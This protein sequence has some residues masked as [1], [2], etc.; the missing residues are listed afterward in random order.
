[1]SNSILNTIGNTPL[2]EI[3]K[4]SPNPKVRILAKLEYF[5][6]GGSI[7]DR[8]ALYMI[9]AAEKSGELKPDKTVLEATSG[10]TGIGLALVCGV[11]G[12]RLLLVMSDS[13]SA[14]R[15]KILKARGAEILLTPGHLGTDGAIEEAYRLAR[16]NPERFFMVDQFNNE[17]NWKSHYHGTAEEIWQQSDA[18]VTTFIACLGTSGTLMGVS[19]KLKQLNPSVQIV[20]VEPYLGHKIQGLKNMKEA[21][22][23][24]IFQK[25][26]L[27]KKVNIDDEEAF[28]MAR[29]LAE[30][31]GLLVGMS[32]G[33]AMA[34]ALKE[35]QQMN[36]GTVVVLLPDGGE[37]Y[38]S[39]SL[40]AVR[41]D[42]GL[43]LYNTL[44]KSKEPFEP[45][46]PGSVSLYSY[47]P[48]AHAR[49][50]IGEMRRYVFADI[51]SRYLRYRGYQVQHVV[52]ITDLDDKTILGSEKAGL[53]LAE[54]T[55]GHIEQ[56]K[57]DLSVLRVRP[58]EK[59]PFAGDHV[60][61]MEELS[62]KLVNKGFAYEKL[63][64]LY[65]DISRFS[66]YGQLSGID[67]HK[68]KLGAT[69][70]LDAYEKE[71]PRDFT[72]FKR[73]RLSE[74]KRG[75]F[76]KTQWGNVRPSWH[77]Q[78]AAL[79]MKYLGDNY[80]IY[81]SSR[82]LLFPHH[83]NVN[84]IAAALTGRPLARFW[85]HCDRVLINGKKVDEADSG[86]TLDDLIEMGYSGR[87]L[88]YWLLTT[89]YRK[90]IT[91][92]KDRLKDARHS[93]KRLDQCLHTL[94]HIRDGKSYPD[95]NQ[96]V[97][98]IKQGFVRAMD[99]DLNI[100]AAMAS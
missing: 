11:K 27:D 45:I 89:H 84:A 40:F 98:D 96:L 87:L 1:M 29:S 76:F 28:E 19:R 41:E 85:I 18:A 58:A 30:T 74:L 73:S 48:A 42:V 99:D 31:E 62:Q 12:Y 82:E 60:K 72:L 2:V 15:Q 75:I 56:F 20:G 8:P 6:P 63:R 49:M 7:K 23:P 66:G 50:H 79:S 51:L 38:L 3:K 92:S 97:Y 80:D 25:Q 17:A 32:S 43:K 93:L 44:S 54:F 69:V 94:K 14:E 5:N 34:A 83:E 53:D 86:H 78:C 39:T 36:A 70:D 71:N 37:R 52:N 35:A 64:S 91:F 46:V 13:V 24:G 90:P 59:Y 55:R 81:A 95:L 100:S 21:Y 65:F 47:G 9:E 10:N 88:R 67:I 57:K 16:E 61:D 26:R 22:C 68:I 4:L 77:I 33:A